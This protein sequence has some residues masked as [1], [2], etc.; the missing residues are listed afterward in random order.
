MKHKNE[1]IRW[2]KCPDETAVW[3][4][5]EDANW[6]KSRYPLW[7]INTI[8]IVDDEWAEIAKQ[9]I[10]D[11]SKIEFHVGHH[12]KST[13][14]SNVHILRKGYIDKYGIKPDVTYY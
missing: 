14:A 13:D 5:T 11:K 7:N 9:F 8:Y 12:R 4:R 6:A 10:D 3:Y 1:I 2:A